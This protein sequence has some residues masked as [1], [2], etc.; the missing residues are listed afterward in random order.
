[1]YR[2]GSSIN[3]GPV[4]N[5]YPSPPPANVSLRHRPPTSPFFSK[6]VTSNPAFASRDAIPSPPTPPPTTI[7]AF[8]RPTSDAVAV[9]RVVAPARRARAPSRAARRSR[10]APARARVASAPRAPPAR[11]AHDD[12]AI[13]RIEPNLIASL[14]PRSRPRAIDDARVRR[15][16]TRA[17]RRRR[18]AYPRRPIAIDRSIA[19]DRSR[20]DRDRVDRS[21]SR[22]TRDRVA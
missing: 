5:L 11:V 12:R 21:R 15:R 7:A 22:S 10:P 16:V 1:M 13:A 19:V 2:S 6:S 14:A 20:V 17:T 4:S 3:D 8:P 18:R 9:A